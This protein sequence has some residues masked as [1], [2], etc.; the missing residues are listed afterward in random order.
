M[1]STQERLE[2]LL[3]QVFAKFATR[4]VKSTDFAP[5]P[6]S[7]W[8]Q[9]DLDRGYRVVAQRNNDDPTRLD[10]YVQF[11]ESIPC[12]RFTIPSLKFEV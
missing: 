6:E 7:E 8:D 2:E 3:D 9:P 5:L 11:R 10:C 4:A 12:S 1:S